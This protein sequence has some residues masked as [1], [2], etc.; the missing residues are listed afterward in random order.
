MVIWLRGF[1]EELGFTQHEPTVLYT[2]SVSAK[3][4][5]DI[6]NI[7]HK[8][9]HLVM[10]IN[11]IHECVEAGIIALKYISSSNEVADVLTKLLPVESHEQHTKFLMEGHNSQQPVEAPILPKENPKN[12]NMFKFDRLTGKWAFKLK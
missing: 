5:A 7:G 11:Y 9:A 2:D 1:L 4:L 12:K 8:S 6:C 10:R 3:A